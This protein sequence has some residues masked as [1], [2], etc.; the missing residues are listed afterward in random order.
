MAEGAWGKADAADEW[1]VESKDK[2]YENKSIHLP[3]QHSYTMVRNPV[4]T[5]VLVIRG[6]HFRTNLG[7]KAWSSDKKVMFL[8]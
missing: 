6:W 8:D 5:R 3:R 4:F 2:K 7:Q 1:G